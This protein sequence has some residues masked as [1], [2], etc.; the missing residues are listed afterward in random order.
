MVVLE[1]GSVLPGEVMR[2]GVLAQLQQGQGERK[3]LESWAWC[4]CRKK[5]SLLRDEPQ[6]HVPAVH[7]TVAPSH[8]FQDLTKQSRQ[9]NH[10]SRAVASQ[11]S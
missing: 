10:G 7:C 2:K 3:I 11:R 5:L 6:A 4:S 9:Q 8:V 1:K